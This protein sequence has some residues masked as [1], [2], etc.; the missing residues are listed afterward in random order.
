MERPVTQIE[1]HPGPSLTIASSWINGVAD[2]DE[3]PLP[4]GSLRM[5]HPVARAEEHAD[6]EE[7]WATT[8]EKQRSS[9]CRTELPP[10]NYGYGYGQAGQT[11]FA[12]LRRGALRASRRGDCLCGSGGTFEPNISDRCHGRHQGEQGPGYPFSQYSMRGDL[13]REP[14]PA[15]SAP[16]GTEILQHRGQAIPDKPL[17]EKRSSLARC[18]HPIQS[19]VSRDI[20]S[21]QQDLPPNPR[22]RLDLLRPTRPIELA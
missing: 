22:Y 6:E 18:I 1:E 17:P 2:R 11:L 8:V 16:S 9:G 19:T 15:L 12:C 20:L 14:L 7:R 4:Q 3:G 5:C 13:S 21:T 10:G